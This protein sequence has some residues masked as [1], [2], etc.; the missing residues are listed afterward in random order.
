MSVTKFAPIMWRTCRVL[1]FAAPTSSSEQNLVW[2]KL[3]PNQIYS[4]R[5]QLIIDA[6][7]LSIGDLRQSFS[8]CLNLYCLRGRGLAVFCSLFD[9]SRNKI[10]AEECLIQS[11]R[12]QCDAHAGFLYLLRQ[13]ISNCVSSDE[14]APML[15]WYQ[16]AG[17]RRSWRFRRSSDDRIQCERRAG[18][19]GI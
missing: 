13:W 16:P 15:L 18:P 19:G 5:K 17:E 10:G 1:V 8:C 3:H 4:K 6:N 7:R 2:S 11:L 9:L 14:A 12:Q